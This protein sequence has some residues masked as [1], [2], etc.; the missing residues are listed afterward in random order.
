[1]ISGD[2]SKPLFRDC[3]FRVPSLMRPSSVLMSPSKAQLLLED[4]INYISAVYKQVCISFT[5]P[6]AEVYALAEYPVAIDERVEGTTCR[7]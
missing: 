7:T 4:S 2:G 5:D 3:R 6:C 1:M